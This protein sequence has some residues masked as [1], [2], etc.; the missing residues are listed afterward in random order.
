MNTKILFGNFY[1]DDKIGNLY[2]ERHADDCI[3][4]MNRNN[5]KGEFDSVLNPLKA[6]MIPFKAELGDVDTSVNVL[7]GK[8][9][10]VDGFIAG[11]VGF[12]KDSYIDIASKL[13]GEKS[14]AFLEFFPRGK[15]EYNQITKT[16]MPTIT[17]RINTAATNNA[18]ALGA[19]LTTKLQSFKTDWVSVRNLQLK[20]K[21]D[22]KG[23]RTERSTARIT[24]ENCLIAAVR[25]VANKYP[26]DEAKCLQ[27]FDF[28]LL[29]G[30]HRN[31]G[32]KGGEG[33]GGAV[34]K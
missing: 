30:V 20:S 34:T 17:T 29:E 13:G 26:G 23:N 28:S 6:G 7:L 12:M 3:A 2:I 5:A 22:L 4:K 16:K 9:Q 10:T 14:A 25:F 15:N 21:A 27:F 11:F 1:S 31:G 33:T 18:T 24:V 19:T 32:D 8:T